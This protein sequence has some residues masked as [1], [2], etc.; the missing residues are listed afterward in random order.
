LKNTSLYGSRA[1][2]CVT[3]KKIYIKVRVYFQFNLSLCYYFKMIG[4]LP[5]GNPPNVNIGTVIVY[6]LLFIQCLYAYWSRTPKQINWT[7][8]LTIIVSVFGV[9]NGA[10]FLS[11]RQFSSFH[12]LGQ[13]VITSFFFGLFLAPLT[14]MVGITLFSVVLK[15]AKDQFQ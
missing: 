2:V 14:W 12:Q 4:N 9:I 11:S 3:W 7:L 1:K 13:L 6:S 5:I 8:H 15:Q 10:L